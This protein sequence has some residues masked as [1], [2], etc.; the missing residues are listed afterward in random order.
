VLPENATPEDLELI[1]TE[2]QMAVETKLEYSWIDRRLK[3][4]TLME[5]YR[6]T[7]DKIAS[8]MHYPNA[9]L[10]KDEI[11]ELA[12]VDEYLAEFLKTPGDY[13]AVSSSEQIFKTMAQS[14]AKKV[15]PEREIAKLMAFTLVKEADKLG[16]RVYEFRE[17]FGKLAPKVSERLAEVLRPSAAANDGQTSTRGSRSDDDDPLSALEVDS[18][19][20]SEALLDALRDQS[21]TQV[22]AQHIAQIHESIKAAERQ[23]TSRNQPLENVIK[24]NTLLSSFDINRAAQESFGEI[25]SHLDVILA[26]A[27]ALRDQVEKRIGTPPRPRDIRG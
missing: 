8:V 6:L 21:K 14:L 17:A 9:G 7:A 23:E 4:Q 24:A 13:K 16:T 20:N 26:K 10:V 5:K 18:N 1:E 15:G 11:R 25:R 22:V 2:L 3:V 12:L 19:T 27:A